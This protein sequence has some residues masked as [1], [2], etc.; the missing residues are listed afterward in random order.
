[1]TKENLL[2]EPLDVKI[3]TVSAARETG[4]F[5][6]AKVSQ[7]FKNMEANIVAYMI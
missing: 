2:I 5:F 3:D 4:K 6:L 7:G 1:M